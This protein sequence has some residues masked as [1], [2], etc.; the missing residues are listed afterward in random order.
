MAKL[1][2][3]RERVQQPYRDSLIR[4]SGLY[5]GSLTAQ[6]N[7]FKN[8]GGQTTAQTNLDSGVT[9]ANDNSMIILALR[10]FLSFRQG[11]VRVGGVSGPVTV[12]GEWAQIPNTAAGSVALGNG[13]PDNFDCYRLY[14]QSNDSIFWTFGVGNK[15]SISSMP[16]A[17]FPYGGGLWAAI[18]GNTDILHVNLG[19]PDHQGIL[20]LARAILLTPRQA[21]ICQ[22]DCQPYP[23]NGQAGAWGIQQGSRNMYSIVDNLN[24]ADG[25]TKN[26]SFTFDGLLS[27]DVQLALRTGDIASD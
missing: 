27:R 8:S 26:V 23:D 3:I 18:G 12:N 13:T 9:L 7:L 19:T 14:E 24:A 6:S 5:P 15:P 11:R 4:T 21:I 16:S 17:Y 2:N 1:T 22:A 20:K 25:I 10:V